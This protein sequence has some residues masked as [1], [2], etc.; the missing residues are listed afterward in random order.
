MITRI[1]RAL[2]PFWKTKVAK[3]IKQRRLNKIVK[4]S[5]G[6]LNSSEKMRVLDMGCNNGMDFL[7][8][9]EDRENIELHGVDIEDYSYEGRNVNFYKTDGSTLPFEDNYFDLTVSIGVLEHVQPIENL[10]QVI[11]EINR[12]SKKYV[13]I[14]PSI[15]TILEPHAVSFFWP[16]RSAKKKVKHSYLNY[17]SDEAWM[18]FNG[19]KDAQSER[20]WYIP[21]L[22][23]NFVIWK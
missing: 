11:S 1:Y 23:K 15:G 6:L 21:G 8:H 9:F 16:I 19:F 12:V 13:V 14:I 5:N 3:K 17:F 22:I 20:F 7:T 4:Y 2:Y 18:Q 10:C